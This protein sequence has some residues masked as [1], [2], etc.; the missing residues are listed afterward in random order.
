MDMMALSILLGL[1]LPIAAHMSLPSPRIEIRKNQ[2]GVL[3][4][5]SVLEAEL[6]KFNSDFK[7]YLPENF[8]PSL[9]EDYVHTSPRLSTNG[10]TTDCASL[11]P[12]PATELPM[13]VVGDFNGDGKNDAVLMGDDKKNHLVLGALSSGK[14]YKISVI[15][16]A[17]YVRPEDSFHPPFDEEDVEESDESES[18]L[19][20]ERG[21]HESLS[22]VPSKAAAA[23]V[24]FYRC[25]PSIKLFA[26]DGVLVSEY[27]SSNNRLYSVVN[28]KFTLYR[29]PP[30]KTKAK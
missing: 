3:Q 21:F 27:L 18:E 13:A 29:P 12:P 30:R 22:Q 7:V 20:R 23:K 10:K 17:K 24:P 14:T 1:S 26:H 28:G 5:G 6:K 11:E 4:L 19:G 2:L 8:V 16:R 25:H 9:V 15:E